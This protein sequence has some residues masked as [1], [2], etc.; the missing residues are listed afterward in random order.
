MK[1]LTSD[2][3]TPRLSSPAQWYCCIFCSSTVFFYANH[4]LV[5][6]FPHFR[7]LVLRNAKVPMLIFFSSLK[8]RRPVHLYYGNL[9]SGGD[10]QK[11]YNS[12]SSFKVITEAPFS[13]DFRSV[14]SQEM[15]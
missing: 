15:R 10:I 4:S 6:E 5:T 14:N 12:F 11:F 1:A 8:K 13:V 9:I 3:N 7:R 2:C